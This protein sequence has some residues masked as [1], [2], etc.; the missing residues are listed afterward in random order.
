M[1]TKLEGFKTS[2]TK[3]DMPEVKAG[4]TIR[5][6]QKIKTKTKKEFKFLKDWF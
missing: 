6:H 3:Q 2:Q 5:V 1:T 4:D